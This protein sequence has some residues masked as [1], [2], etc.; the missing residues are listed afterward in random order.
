MKRVTA[1]VLLIVLVVVV[2][3]ASFYCGG[4]VGFSQGY[5]FAIAKDAPTD[6][7][8]SVILLK[9]IKNDKIDSAVDFLEKRVNNSIVR[10][11]Y[12]K[13]N[14]PM[15]YGIHFYD[16]SELMNQATTRMMTSACEYRKENPYDSDERTSKR[17]ESVLKDYL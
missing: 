1:Y 2:S 13:K 5:N 10:H 12:H 4:C 8:A 15:F 16:K 11:W 14:P 3:A 7:M 6:A 17:V 9:S